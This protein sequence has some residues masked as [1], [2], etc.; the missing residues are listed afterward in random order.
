MKAW[1]IQTATMAIALAIGG[2]TSAPPAPAAAPAV[3]Y[4][5]T[6]TGSVTLTDVG[7]GVAVA[8]CVTPPRLTVQV[9]NNT[10]TY[11]QP[12]PGATISEPGTPSGASETTTYM[13]TIAPN[14][15][16]SGQS[17]MAGT[18]SGVISGTHMSGQIEGLECVYTFTADRT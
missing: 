2:C 8:G 12:H 11:V 1:H 16:F 5:G 9:K 6:Y 14:G 10:F 15:S 3:S 17:E 4:D 13:N 7:A 18:M